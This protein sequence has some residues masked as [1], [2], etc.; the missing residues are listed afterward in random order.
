MLSQ[1]VQRYLVCIIISVPLLTSSSSSDAI[2]SG[3]AT[4]GQI[5]VQLDDRAA[6]LAHKTAQVR[7]SDLTAAVSER[8]FAI[9]V[10]NADVARV[11][12]EQDFVNREY[13]RT[14]VLF[15]RGLVNE[16]TLD[17]A[18]RRKLGVEKYNPGQVRTRSTRK[19][20]N[21]ELRLLGSNSLVLSVDKISTL[22]TNRSTSLNWM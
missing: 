14:R 12:E 16:T 17:A 8:A 3:T 4:A 18:E 19:Y 6:N 11:S 13:D 1:H 9:T 5:L 15:Q 20:E 2:K 10:A 7:L 22:G 21:Q